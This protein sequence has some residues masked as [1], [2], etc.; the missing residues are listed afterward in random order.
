MSEQ[1]ANKIETAYKELKQTIDQID[2]LSSVIDHIKET[3]QDILE[4]YITTIDPAKL[5]QIREQNKTALKTMIED[6][7]KIERN[8]TDF[9]VV[10]Q[11]TKELVDTFSSRFSTFDDVFKKTKQSITELDN[12]LLKLIKEAEK[13]QRLGQNRF[14]QASKLF[15][16]S[17]EVE[18]YD[19]LLALEKENNR[20]LKDI[21]SKMTFSSVKPNA[22]NLKH[23]FNQRN[24]QPAFHKNRNN[25]TQKK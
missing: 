9:D 25:D 4:K 6:V 24:K 18:K 22:D 8:M 10:S 20:I 5:T 15:H 12:K 3:S 13:Q 14:L 7:Q 16:A 11:Q 23:D 21:Q 17:A 2:L 19:Q 1:L